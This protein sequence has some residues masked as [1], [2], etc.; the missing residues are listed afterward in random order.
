MSYDLYI[1]QKE[2]GRDPHETI[3]SILA[4]EEDQAED[5]SKEMSQLIKIAYE[6]IKENIDF[7]EVTSANQFFNED[8]GLVIDFCSNYI[9]LN[10]AY[11]HDDSKADEIFNKIEEIITQINSDNQFAI[12]DPQDDKIKY[13]LIASNESTTYAG[14][15]QSV[16]GL[17]PKKPWW[18]FW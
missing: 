2:E 11:W 15:V 8:M 10:L 3:K 7:L 6:N 4:N 9:S 13:S 12:Y 18:K 16:K 1:F 17:L 14:T 5:I